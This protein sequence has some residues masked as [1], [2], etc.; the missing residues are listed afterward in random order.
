MFFRG[1]SD[2]T[3]FE[4]LTF[5]RWHILFKSGPDKALDFT[6]VY[7]MPLLCDAALSF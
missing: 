5:H 3:T 4:T 6:R 1:I 7:S 2:A